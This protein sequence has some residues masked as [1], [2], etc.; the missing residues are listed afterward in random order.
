[1]TSRHYACQH[2]LVDAEAWGNSDHFLWQAN[3][4][5][6]EVETMGETDLE[7]KNVLRKS[8][9][10]SFPDAF[11]TIGLRRRSMKPPW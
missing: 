2:V 9:A 8:A 4:K 7:S 11:S 1:M 3:S 6:Q 5:R 10:I